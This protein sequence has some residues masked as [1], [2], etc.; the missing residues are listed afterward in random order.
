MFTCSFPE[1]HN[2][3]GVSDPTSVHDS[4]PTTAHISTPTSAPVN[5]PTSADVSTHFSCFSFSPPV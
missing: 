1:G 3:A 5:T 2:I 4:T